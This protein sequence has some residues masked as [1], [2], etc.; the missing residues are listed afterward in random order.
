MEKF[1]LG[2]HHF[3]IQYVAGQPETYHRQARE[4]IG[5]FLDLLIHHPEW[6]MNVEFQGYTIEF[7]A[8]HYPGILEKLRYLVCNTK[9]I[10]LIS[11]HYSPQLWIAFPKYDMLKSIQINDEILHRHGLERS[12]IFFAQENFTGEGIQVLSKFFDTV[13]LKED[14][15]C[16]LYGPQEPRPYYTMGPMRAVIGAAH[17]HQRISEMAYPDL[18]HTERSD[19]AD[20][21][22]IDSPH[23]RSF[24][25]ERRQLNAERDRDR[26]Y[27]PKGCYKNVHWL[28]YH[29]GSSETFAKAQ[30]LPQDVMGCWFNPYWLALTER[31]LLDIQAEGFSLRTVGD[32]LKKADCSGFQPEP[33]Q[34]IL[35]GCWSMERSKG[36][37]PW[38]GFHANPYETDCFIRSHNWRTRTRLL[39]CECLMRE[40][41]STRFDSE[42]VER[43]IKDA[44]RHQLL[45]ECSD[46][47]GWIPTQAEV[48]Y[49]IEES[50]EVANLVGEAI[51]Q[52]KRGTQVGLLSVD[53]LNGKVMPYHNGQF[54][55][56]EEINIS[57]SL[58]NGLEIFGHKSKVALYKISECMQRLSIQLNP[59]GKIMGIGFDLN[60]DH[61][62]YSPTLMEDHLVSY[63]LSQFVFEEIYLP[64]SNGL[65]ALGDQVYLIKHND[66]MH[67]ACCINKKTQTVNFQVEN[68]RMPHNW[69][70]TLF[71][72]VEEQALKLAHEINVW[73]TV[74]V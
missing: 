74:V 26:F 14:Y 47:T 64:L 63:P 33:L 65:I 22:H 62:T 69:T 25:K 51:S 44:W 35:D 72:G 19:I 36:I 5:P 71:K 39:A 66:T 21:F 73:P 1:A 45:A 4:A 50:D 30:V 10:E 67:V 20:Q 54:P 28:W 13:V 12:R 9:Q 52:L 32:F 3:N 43:K 56:L 18:D 23:D 7:I 46:S 59:V 29:I 27:P 37:F 53:T 11:C 41:K 58:A 68:A 6:R 70:L 57:E 42:A 31:S 61:I 38:M 17:F 15:Y 34:P 49:S 8:E 16:Y 24:L 60:T 55:S 40:S 2:I 48:A